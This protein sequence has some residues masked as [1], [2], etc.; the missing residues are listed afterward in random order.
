MVRFDSQRNSD[1][2]TLDNEVTEAI[3]N[4][5]RQVH[6]SLSAAIRER[7]LHPLACARLS[8]ELRAQ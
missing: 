5:G 2:A 3:D 4:H 7:K 1:P 8:V 6:E